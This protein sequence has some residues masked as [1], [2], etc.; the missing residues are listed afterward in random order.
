MSKQPLD[1][2]PLQQPQ[3][4]AAIQAVRGSVAQF[5]MTDW[6]SDVMHKCT[7]LAV[8]MLHLYAQQLNAGMNEAV[9]RQFV[10]YFMDVYIKYHGGVEFFT[11]MPDIDQLLGP[12][13]EVIPT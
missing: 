2:D 4:H 12:E 7:K 8:F 6:E 10:M 3:L 9:S 11:E 1:L 13:S 5:H